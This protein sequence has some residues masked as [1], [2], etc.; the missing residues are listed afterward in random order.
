M[1]KKICND[2]IGKPIY[3]GDIVE[4]FIGIEMSTPWKSEVYWNM[5]D[6]AFVDAHPGQVKMGLSIHRH[7]R[8]FINKE[9]VKTVNFDGEQTILETYCKKIKNDR[10]NKG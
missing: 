8:D 6:G 4:L 2:S 10:R 3:E 1:K 7:L 9:T 5:L